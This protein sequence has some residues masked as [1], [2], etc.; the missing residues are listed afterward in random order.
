MW[1]PPYEVYNNE[2][3]ER[4]ANLTLADIP[5]TYVSYHHAEG[6]RQCPLSVLYKNVCRAVDVAEYGHKQAD[7][8]HFFASNSADLLGKAFGYGL[9]YGIE[10]GVE[11]YRQGAKQ[12]DGDLSQELAYRIQWLK[13]R[14]DT[15]C[16]K[17]GRIDYEVGLRGEYK[18][19]KVNC[20]ADAVF[21]DTDKTV[22]LEIKH[23]NNPKWILECSG[24]CGFYKG[25]LPQDKPIEAFYVLYP[26]WQAREASPEIC[27]ARDVDLKPYYDA[28]DKIIRTPIDP[29]YWP[30]PGREINRCKTCPVQKLCRERNFCWTKKLE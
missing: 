6:Y 26:G 25:L 4:H 12:A 7:G 13:S 28:L 3:F 2:W 16:A 5:G 18:G 27:K 23:T 19:V 14:L 30:S 29:E 15:R 22:L 11:Y 17:S 8:C 21:Y 10:A 1:T 24:Q 9:Q 20:T